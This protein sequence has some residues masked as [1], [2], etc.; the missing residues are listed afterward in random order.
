L[1]NA[2]V[3]YSQLGNM[4]KAEAAL[5]QAIAS[6]PAQ[7]AAHFNLGLLLAETGYRKEAAK[8]LRRTLELDGTNAA[9]AYNLAVLIA[10]ENPGEALALCRKAAI[11]RPDDPKYKTAV[12]YYEGRGT[13]R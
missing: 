10:N 4:P 9:A 13:P 1:V 7:P 11:L 12:T 6:E 8:E 2:A 5:R 3:V